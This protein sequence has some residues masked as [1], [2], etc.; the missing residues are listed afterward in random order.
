M[1]AEDEPITLKEKVCRPV[2]RRQSMSHDRTVRPVV[3]RDSSHA[4]GQEIQRQNSE[5]EQ[6]RTLPTEGA[7]PRGLSGADSK[8]RIPG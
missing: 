1:R 7:N 8:A 6:I 2:C 5:S 4:Q 3:C